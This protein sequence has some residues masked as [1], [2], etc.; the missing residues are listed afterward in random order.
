[1][2]PSNSDSLSIG[3]RFEPKGPAAL[4]L[5]A[6]YWRIA[7]D[8]TITIPSPARLLAAEELFPDR[9]IRGQPSA[10][11][12]EAGIPG[13][14]QAI[15]ITRLNN[16]AI[17]TSGVDVSAYVDVDTRMGRFK[18]QLS[19]TW[20]HD[21]T[22]S[23]LVEGPGVNR[24]SVASGQGTVPRWRALAA[25][26]WSHAGVG[27]F[28]AMRYVPS[29]DD[30]DFQGNRNGRKIDSQAIVDVQLS[31]DLGIMAGERSPWSGFEIR[32]GA[33]NLFNADPPFA[34]VGGPAGYDATQGDL[35]RRFAYLK[36][37]KKF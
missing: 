12:I 27:L 34:E 5:G 35:R 25:V 29:Y 37:A 7:I 21:F 10:A 4:R 15:D 17:R 24:V 3:L 19:G 32:A 33:F 22:T 14:L 1:M 20:V 13:P 2:K 18:P 36:L 31:L 23:D 28:G 6:N 8:Q 30:T 16:G 26:S 9:V 11:D